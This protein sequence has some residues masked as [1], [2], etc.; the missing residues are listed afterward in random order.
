VNFTLPS[1]LDESP[2]EVVPGFRKLA[3][4]LPGMV[5]QF[6]RGA[7]GEFCFPCASEGIRNI[8]RLV[9]AEVATDASR[10]FAAIHPEDRDGFLA[11]IRDSAENLTPWVGEYRTLFSDGTVRWV[12]SNASVEPQP[13]GAVLW[14]GFFT[15]VTERKQTEVAAEA[16]RAFLQSIY[17]TV[18]LAIFVIDATPEGDFRYMEVNPAFERLTGIPGTEIRGR[19]PQDLVPVVS[20]EMAASLRIN[21]RRCRDAAV[22]LEYEESITWR[23]RRMWWLTRL[24]PLIAPDG[25]VTRLIG[26]SLDITERKTIEL[27]LHTMSERLQ[28]ATESGHIGIWDFDVTLKT[29]AWDERM[30]ALYGFAPD[31]FNGDYATWIGCVHPDDRARMEQVFHEAV[32][33]GMVFDTSFRIIRRDGARRFI[34]ACAHVQRDAAENPFRIVGINWDVTAEHESQSE[35]VRARDEAE[36]LNLQ[37]KEALSRAQRFAEEA[38]AATVAKSEFLANMSHE[39]RTPLNGVIGMGGLLLGTELSP[40]QREFAETIRSSGD[41]LLAL[42][43]DILDYTKIESGRL[44]LE[45]N[46]FDLR[47]CVE[48]ALDVLSARAAEKNIDLVYWIEE[49]VP[50]AFSGDITR[51]RQVIVNLLGN[52]VK[53]TERGE[54]FLYVRLVDAMIAGATRLHFAVRDTGIGIPPDR[55]DRLFKTFSQVDASTTRQYGGT[56]LGLAISK[57]IVDLMCGRI[58]VESSVGKGSTFQFEVEMPA[59]PE[60]AITRPHLRGP[61]PAL[62]G[63]DLLIVDDNATNARILALQTVA[64]GL[65]PH[66]TSS[67]AEA[68]ELLA[69]GEKFDLGIL[70]M[71]MP[72]MDGHQLAAEI[73]RTHDQ[74][75]LPLL[76]LTSL[77]NSRAPAALGFTACVS[78]PIKPA[79]L[80]N[81]IGDALAGQQDRRRAANEPKNPVETLGARHPLSILMA[82]DNLV[83]QRVAL[84]MLKRLGYTADVANNGLEAIQALERKDYDL[85]LTDLQMPEMDGIQAA[86]EILR[87]WPEEKRPCI[88]AMTANASVAD[89]EQC[90]AVGMSDFISKPVRL[91]DLRGAIEKMI[92]ARTGAAKK[93]A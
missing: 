21:Y 72:R 61:V 89:R 65:I 28:L 74:A 17:V 2:A 40:E 80:F 86:Q 53:F 83:N 81:L 15:D 51:L 92:S 91:E 29:L 50:A 30:L 48:S 57:R 1:P 82:E 60:A 27:R 42:I 3:D 71:Q 16:N 84:L 11:A 19:R 46:P 63:K 67:G 56:G 59:A 10:V 47:E 45:Q 8:F 93:S 77:G 7:A 66:V 13:D 49:D 44:E 64:W 90:F 52:A 75:R 70:D 24:T 38:S 88:I 85:L 23:G 35:I 20:A 33:G 18:D 36:K 25:S 5:F 55:M 39:I 9:P 73:R 58:W 41:T 87:K 4:Q 12:G 22:P 54:V 79:L 43:N 68:L 32:T 78:K 6:R 26:R 31:E 62:E 76:L 34:R 37:L 14:Q 69:R